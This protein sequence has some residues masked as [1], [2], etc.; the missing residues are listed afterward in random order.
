LALK[1]GDVLYNQGDDAEV[2]YILKDGILSL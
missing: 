2:L 1:T